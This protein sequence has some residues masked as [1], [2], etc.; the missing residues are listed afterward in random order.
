M[1][2]TCDNCIKRG[3]CKY[4]IEIQHFVIENWSGFERVDASLAVGAWLAF[5]GDRCKEYD[6]GKTKAMRDPNGGN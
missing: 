1:K 5:L 2:Q 6:N 4:R 3:T